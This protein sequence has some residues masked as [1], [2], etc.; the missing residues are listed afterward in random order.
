MASA[1]DS[2][3]EKEVRERSF[4][5]GNETGGSG[6]KFRRDFNT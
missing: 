6:T 5:N 2:V 3:F 4:S 1:K